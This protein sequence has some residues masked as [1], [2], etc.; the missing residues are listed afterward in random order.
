MSRL[1]FPQE[2]ETG[3]EGKSR[4][5]HFSC[6]IAL[7]SPRFLAH[8]TEEGSSHHGAAPIQLPSP[9]PRSRAQ[10]AHFPADKTHSH[11]AA[12][13]APAGAPKP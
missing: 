3:E 11:R 12:T 7:P 2:Q 1:D 10:G 13:A 9:A 4:R 6:F 5:I 8:L